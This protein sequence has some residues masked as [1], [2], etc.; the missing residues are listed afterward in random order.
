MFGPEMIANTDGVGQAFK[1]VSRSRLLWSVVCVLAALPAS[2]YAQACPTQCIIGPPSADD[3]GKQCAVDTDCNYCNPSS[4][5][6][7]QPTCDALAL[8]G[9]ACQARAECVHLEWRPTAIGATGPGQ[10]VNLD[11]YA[12]SSTGFDQEFESVEAILN[13]DPTKLRLLGR[14]DPCEVFDPCTEACP[15]NSYRWL[16]ST[17]PNDCNSDSLNTP[18][19]GD[20]ENDGDAFYIAISRILCGINQPAA[21]PIAT[22][23]GLHVTTIQFEVLSDVGTSSTVSLVYDAGGDARTR[24]LGGST[25]AEVVTGLLPDPVSVTVEACAAPTVLGVGSRVI[26]IDPGTAAGEVGFYIESDDPGLQCI[27]R[28]AQADG[29]LGE[30]AFFQTPAAWGSAVRLRGLRIIPEANYRVYTDCGTPGAP[31]FSPPAFVT[32]ELWADTNS[33]GLAD[34]KDIS[35]SVSAFLGGL[36]TGNPPIRTVDVDV[37]GRGDPNPVLAA[38][39]KCI[40]DDVVDFRDISGFVEAFLGFDSGNPSSAQFATFCDIDFCTP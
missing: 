33:D 12:V 27:G 14:V 34:F 6:F 2:V 1:T 20:P 24:V 19:P 18:C 4:P 11:L 38:I 30:G 22:G 13:W 3:T 25:G 31:A 5:G 39:F 16:S 40:P 29:A 26:E 9:G 8:Q 35:R 21:N 17:F 32:M 36:G 23:A 10:I 28:W 15:A 7:D 37:I